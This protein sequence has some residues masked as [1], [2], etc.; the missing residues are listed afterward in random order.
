MSPGKPLRE[1]HAEITRN[2][3]ISA[4]RAEFAARGYEAVS[5]DEIAAAARVTKGAIYHH[6]ANK[7]DLFRT[8]YEQLAGEVEDRVRRR[9]ARAGNPLER[10]ELAID[11]FLECADDDAI[12][13]VMFRDGPVALAGE[14]RAIDARY[15]LAL[16]KQLLDD[17][18]VAGLLAD[19]DTAM[20]ARLLLGVLIE[21]S[22][23]LG[24]PE[25][26][27]HTRANLRLALRRMLGG[28]L[29]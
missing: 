20:V 24:D 27:R 15:Y 25:R 29:R 10:A 26:P 7:R 6:F 11:A 12:R 21:G 23:L 3:V 1:E 28:F 2:A 14:C 18:A 19:V 16:L 13:T 22:A 17:F 4:A 5:L 9:I 8:V